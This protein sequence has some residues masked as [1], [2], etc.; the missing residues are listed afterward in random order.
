MVGN[1]N[2][3]FAFAIIQRWA[4]LAEFPRKYNYWIFIVD[5]IWFK[6][7]WGANFIENI[8]SFSLDLWISHKFEKKY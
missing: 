7:F 6:K 8:I 3:S 2:L 1:N 4:H 5:N